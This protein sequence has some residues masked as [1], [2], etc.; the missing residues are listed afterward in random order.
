[1]IRLYLS[2][3][4]TAMVLS[5]R[6]QLLPQKISVSASMASTSIGDLSSITP[7]F[8]QDAHSYWFPGW[9]ADRYPAKVKIDFGKPVKLQNIRIWDGTGQPYLSISGVLNSGE[10]PF[11]ITN[12]HLDLWQQWQ[13]KSVDVT[14][15]Y[16]YLILSDAQGDQPVGEIEFFGLPVNVTTDVTDTTSTTG[17]DPNNLVGTRSVRTGD[18]LKIGVNGFHW[19]PTNL[20]QP[21]SYYR[22]YQMWDWME[23]KQGIN[24]FSPTDYANGYYDSHYAELK[25]KGIRPIACVNTTPSWLTQGYPFSWHLQDNKPIHWWEDPNNPASYDEF[26]RFFWQLAARYGRNQQPDNLLTINTNPRWNNDNPLNQKKSGLNLL[27]F[28]EVWNEP[29]KWWLRSLDFPYFTP[30]QYAAMLSACYDGHEGTLGP[31]FGIKTADPSMKVVM[32]GLT[33]FDLDY[34]KRMV[35]WCKT[36]RKDQRFPADVVNFHHYSNVRS[37]LEEFFEYGVS[38]EQD[39]LRSKLSTVVAWCKSNIPGAAFWFSEF[40]YDTTPNSSQQA[41]PFGPYS[42]YTVQGMW[43]QRAYLESIAAGVDVCMAYNICDENTNNGL[44]GNSGLLTNELSG[45]AKKESWFHIKTLADNLNGLTFEKDISVNA[46]V[47]IYQFKRTDG[48][49]V[50]VI[51]SADSRTRTIPFS[52]APNNQII[53]DG[54]PKFVPIAGYF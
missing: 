3:L 41:V 8:D 2:L 51:W 16:V 52:G 49:K 30:E 44:F 46:E 15:R 5:A 12:I 54:F 28:I 45:F 13:T 34:L 6:A 35:A 36:H 18:A 9:Q 50:I 53:S 31:G 42:T 38:P 39:Q 17:L 4:F 26:A 10:A 24:R 47:R 1:M 37:G 21:F 19:V 43:L 33:N 23:N 48:G 29:D 14:V 11:L 22:E 25:E 7:L 20:L 27:E 40:G 32:A